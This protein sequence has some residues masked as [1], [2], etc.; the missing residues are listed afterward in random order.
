MEVRLAGDLPGRDADLPARQGRGVGRTRFSDRDRQSDGRRV[1][2]LGAHDLAASRRAVEYRELC[3]IRQRGRG[4]G[5]PAVR[6][7]VDVAEPGVVGTS[8]RRSHARRI[9]RARLGAAAPR[10]WISRRARPLR[11]A[12][13]GR[14][15]GTTSGPTLLDL[16]ARTVT[17]VRQLPLS[18][19]RHL[20][21]PLLDK[22]ALVALVAVTNESPSAANGAC[23][24]ARIG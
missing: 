15:H 8:R 5:R 22:A 10:R 4:R 14:S 2:Y 1:R 11:D 17:S 12:G 20:I 16:S 21:P 18:R 3:D 23:D 13:A 7:G 9:S 19:L 6:A 24:I